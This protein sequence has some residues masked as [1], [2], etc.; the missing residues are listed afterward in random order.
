MGYNIRSRVREGKSFTY[1]ER[2]SAIDEERAVSC[3]S[4]DILAHL[5]ITHT[6]THTRYDATARN[7]EKS[8]GAGESGLLAFYSSTK[9]SPGRRMHAE[10]GIL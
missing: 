2:Q 3:F 5:N 7:A 1:R 8:C 10:T 9:T 4:L 6:H